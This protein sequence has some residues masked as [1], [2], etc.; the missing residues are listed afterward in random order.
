M[1]IPL[2]KRKSN[3]DFCAVLDQLEDI[4]KSS[5]NCISIG[6]IQS[7]DATNQTATILLNYKSK[8][9]YTGNETDYQP[10][11]K[12]P[13][14]ILNGGGAYITFPI[15]KGDSCLV[16]FCDREIDTWFTK[17]G[18]NAPQSARV[19]DLNDG[20]ALI[21]IKNTGNFI[22]GY[23]TDGPMMFYKGSY[24]AI[25]N[26]GNILMSS[27]DNATITITGNVNLVATGNLTIKG[28]TVDI[29]PP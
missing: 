8:D 6:T 29:N 18:T 7:F 3:P 26:S 14:F 28:A 2:N 25:D 20:I 22:A 9:L 23:Y 13:V 16:L 24:I 21:G 5:L 1:T 10:L 17:G 11:V 15:A 27:P 12:C 19:H 4:I